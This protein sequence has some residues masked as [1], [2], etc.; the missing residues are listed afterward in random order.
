MKPIIIKKFPLVPEGHP[1]RGYLADDIHILTGV[2]L[3]FHCLVR[4]VKCSA[5]AVRG[6]VLL[7]ERA[8]KKIWDQSGDENKK[9]I[10][11]CQEWAAA[12]LA[13]ERIHDR[14]LRALKAMEKEQKR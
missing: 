10:T 9:E 11:E 5:V 2:P 6:C 12:S 4:A 14:C 8:D 3:D 1:M 7:Y 13:W